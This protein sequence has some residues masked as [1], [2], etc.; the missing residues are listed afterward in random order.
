MTNKSSNPGF[1]F[2]D[3]TFKL[4]DI[5]VGY[6]MVHISDAKA[7]NR[8]LFTFQ[9]GSIRYYIDAVPSPRIVDL[10]V[11][12]SNGNPVVMSTNHWMVD[13][14]PQQTGF[15]QF[16]ED[17]QGW[18]WMFVMSTQAKH[19]FRTRVISSVAWLL[20]KMNEAKDD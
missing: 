9:N 15:L 18:P 8:V 2:E 17:A 1:E 19:D 12:L 20:H 16:D 14:K 13:I 11:L 6:E 4:V 7:S 10:V 3:V 5:E